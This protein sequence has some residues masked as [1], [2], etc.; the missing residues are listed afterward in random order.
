MAD[1][2]KKVDRG[3]PS[4][5]RTQSF[6]Q[7]D[8]APGDIIK[9]ED[10]LGRPGKSLRI[11]AVTGSAQFRFNVVNTVYVNRSESGLMYSDG[12]PNPGSGLVYL[13]RSKGSIWVEAG[14]T[15]TSNEFPI[16]DIEVVTRSGTFDIFVT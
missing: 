1:I 13:D 3:V 11:E 15:W 9:V 7:G 5:E 2:T 6:T 10:S 8:A 4:I 16:R 14:T 12:Q